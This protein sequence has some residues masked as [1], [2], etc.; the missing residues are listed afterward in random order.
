MCVL[1]FHAS[2][3]SQCQEK[4]NDEPLAVLQSHT[5]MVVQVSLQICECSLYL[6]V[7]IWHTWTF[8]KCEQVGYVG[9]QGACGLMQPPVR[10]LCLARLEHRPA[11]NR[12]VPF[13]FPPGEVSHKVILTGC[14]ES[15]NQSLQ[16]S[17]GLQPGLLCQVAPDDCLH[18]KLAHLYPVAGEQ[19]EQARTPVKDEAV[20]RIASRSDAVYRSQVVGVRLALDEGEVERMTAGV[21]KPQHHAPVVP[22]VSGV[23]VHIPATVQR[24]LVP[25]KLHALQ[26]PLY[27]RLAH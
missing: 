26:T 21:I 25:F 8:L 18:V 10:I 14:R 22:P 13:F 4:P 2:S 16:L 15:F 11:E 12:I 5:A 1:L 19:G 23:K 7:S 27:G 9:V 20:Y 24:R 3:L 6:V 17:R